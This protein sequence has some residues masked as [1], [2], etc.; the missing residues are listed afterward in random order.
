MASIYNTSSTFH[1]GDLTSMLD[2]TWPKQNP[3]FSLL[4]LF[5]LQSLSFPY[6]LMALSSAQVLKPK[7]Q[8]SSFIFFFLSPVCPTHQQG[9]MALFPIF[10]PYLYILFTSQFQPLFQATS[11]CFLNFVASGLL[12]PILGSYN[13]FYPQ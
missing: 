13:I 2:P 5:L 8:V 10:I 3:L 7:M 4:N 11:I 9:L 12:V 1:I 6:Q